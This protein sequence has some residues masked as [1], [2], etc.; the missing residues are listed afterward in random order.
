MNYQ[1]Q[2]T[3]EIARL[4]SEIAG[5]NITKSDSW[6]IE[7]TFDTFFIRYYLLALTVNGVVSC[8]LHVIVWYVIMFKTPKEM[9][10]YRIYLFNISICS[11]FHDVV[12]SIF[13]RP[14][15]LFPNTICTNT[16]L[17]Q[18][19]GSDYAHF[20]VAVGMPAMSLNIMSIL[21]G[22]IYRIVSL[23]DQQ[24]LKFLHSKY[25]L[26]IMGVIQFG[27]PVLL[28]GVLM[29]AGVPVEALREKAFVKYPQLVPIFESE[30]VFGY[31]AELNAWINVI[32]VLGIICIMVIIP[33][34]EILCFLISSRQLKAVRQHISAHTYQLNRNLIVVLF[35]QVTLPNVMI[36]AP[37]VIVVILIWQEV[38]YTNIMLEACFLSCSFHSVIDNLIMLFAITPYRRSLKHMIFG[39]TFNSNFDESVRNNSKLHMSKR[40]SLMPKI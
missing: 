26:L 17:V 2:I 36:L 19:F 7:Y 11:F 14:V 38:P 20:G 4:K 15:S 16:G 10:D 22:I 6:D 39:K 1:N 8:V 24:Y 33:T 40:M 21:I 32:C 5:G 23:M 31:D 28:G 12:I 3:A 29:L 27:P 35:I 34:T 9:H 13:W 18:Y 25:G 37:A 30:S